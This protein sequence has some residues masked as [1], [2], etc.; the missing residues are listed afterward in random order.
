MVDTQLKMYQDHIIRQEKRLEEMEQRQTRQ[1]HEIMEILEERLTKKQEEMEMRLLK[2]TINIQSQYQKMQK[3]E[4]LISHSLKE[5]GETYADKVSY[6]NPQREPPKLIITAKDDKTSVN[7]I[8][9][10]LNTLDMSELPRMKCQETRRRNLVVMCNSREDLEIIKERIYGK[11]ELVRKIDLREPKERLARIIIFG[12]PEAPQLRRLDDEEVDEEER[13]RSVTEQDIYDKQILQPALEKVLRNKEINYKII[14]VLRGRKGEGNSHLVIQLPEIQAAR[15]LQQKFPIGFNMCT[16]KRYISI[17]RCYHCQQFGYAA[18]NCCNKQ[19]CAKCGK[20]HNARD[21]NEKRLDCVNCRIEVNR[22]GGNYR[23]A[24]V[25]TQ[26]A[27]YDPQC[28]MYL[29]RRQEAFESLKRKQVNS[30]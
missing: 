22:H 19:A 6:P 1:Q 2:H 8:K 29:R 15:L 25:H 17:L 7:E 14:K 30:S 3:E 11:E 16:A 10:V 5:V 4:T 20:E 28:R 23:S 18:K 27:S 26:H 12:A 13:T 21:C 24:G 9:K